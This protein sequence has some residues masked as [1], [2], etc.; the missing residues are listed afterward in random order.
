ML[1][2]NAGHFRKT[3]MLTVSVF[4]ISVAGF[5]VPAHADDGEQ[6]VHLHKGEHNLTFYNS[7]GEA[8]FRKPAATTGELEIYNVAEEND[9][10]IVS[11]GTGN[12]ENNLTYWDAGERP[13]AEP[14]D[15]GTT[16]GPTDFSSDIDNSDNMNTS[17]TASRSNTREDYIES[18]R[19]TDLQPEDDVTQIPQVEGDNLTVNDAWLENQSTSTLRDITEN[20]DTN[21]NAINDARS[22][23][24]ER[25]RRAVADGN[26]SSEETQNSEQ[27]PAGDIHPGPGTH[28]IGKGDNR[29]NPELAR[30][31]RENKD[32]IPLGVH[33]GGPQAMAE[34]LGWQGDVKGD[35]DY[36]IPGR[37]DSSAEGD[38]GGGDNSQ[39]DSSVNDPALTRLSRQ[40]DNLNNQIEQLSRALQPGLFAASGFTAPAAGIQPYSFYQPGAEAPLHQRGLALPFQRFALQQQRNSRLARRAAQGEDI[41]GVRLDPIRMPGNGP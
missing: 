28:F 2:E 13:T 8:V 31:I 17:D 22:R 12:L 34:H 20:V 41:S 19:N 26:D 3:L 29:L 40:I 32:N 5:N 16:F 24:I 15:P 30:E 33:T 1:Y 27:D 11:S 10:E 38:L 9:Y 36:T 21:G 35:Y 25:A 6:K 18:I 37:D 7:D 4:A 39:W 23:E 14:G